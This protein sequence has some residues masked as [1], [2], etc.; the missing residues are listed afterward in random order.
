MADRTWTEL[1]VTC[2]KLG[3]DPET[4]PM[5]DFQRVGG[6]RNRMTPEGWERLINSDAI[7]K[8]CGVCGLKIMVNNYGDRKPRTPRLAGMVICTD[9][10]PR[11]IDDRHLKEGYRLLH[12][13]R[14]RIL[15]MA[16][17]TRAMATQPCMREGK[18]KCKC[19]ACTARKVLT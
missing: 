19:P 9:C 13:R 3:W 5:E 16:Q 4:V 1:E 6:K 17:I 11:H 14:V 12:P 2:E 7:W 10:D 8:Q 18:K 15:R